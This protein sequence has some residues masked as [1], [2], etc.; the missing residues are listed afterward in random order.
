MSGTDLP[1]FDPNEAWD[2]LHGP[3]LPE[4]HWTTENLGEAAPG[5]LTPL[6]A[7]IWG[8]AG[9][10]TCR[11][12][13]VTIG[14]LPESEREPASRLEDRYV[15]I[16]CGRL[17]MSIELLTM[18]G[19]RLPGASGQDI[20]KA[21]LGKVPDDI[22]YH[23]TRRRY[24]IIAYKLGRN[25]LTMPRRLAQEPPKF[26]RFWRESI[27]ALA[28]ADL[29]TTWQILKQALEQFYAA[30]QLQSLA[31]SGHA[32]L[33]HEA[34]GG[35]IRD[36]GVGDMSVLSGSGG[37]EM[38]VIGDIWRAS[39]GEIAIDQVIREHG[40]HGPLEGE[41]SS[42]VWREDPTP[43]K[44]L[45]ADYADREDPRKREAASNARLPAAQAEVIAALPR[46][47]R[48]RG[49]LV[50]RMAATRIPLRGVAK[51]SFLQALDVI[52]A[53]ARRVGTELAA[54]GTLNEPDDAFYLTS[55]ELLDVPAN[56]KELVSLRRR[57]RHEYQNITIPAS[58]KGLPQPEPLATADTDGEDERV[59]TIEG[60][61]VSA[62]V[63]EGIA[64]VV[65]DP[66][67]AE[68]EPDEILVASTTDPSWASIMYVS[69]ALVMDVGGPI[70][71]AAVVAR[72]LG[73]P[74][75]VNTRNGTRAIKTGDRVRV[76]GG[77]GTVEILDPVP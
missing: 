8:T 16:F 65:T 75:V 15:R 46:S 12:T 73:L 44:R 23:P 36:A 11:G 25:F 74:C 69:S 34:L 58:W 49:K 61:G 19:D 54:N 4:L 7:S 30:L 37:A 43:L 68:V 67:F 56:A 17:A 62:G 64:R 29:P 1:A 50:L 27:D 77:H 32:Q 66:S 57:R 40:F 63:R 71:H 21:L 35:V 42:T 39:R 3:S 31:V 47:R 38:A 5:V 51:R 53:C 2:N 55:D 24:P 13:F 10:R 22:E 18:H 14:V 59:R 72:E 45:V 52:R 20:A 41:V 6:G 26:A 33:I 60:I 70:S 76:D 9:E 28:T 48:L